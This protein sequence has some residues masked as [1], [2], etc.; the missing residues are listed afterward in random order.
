MLSKVLSPICVKPLFMCSN[1]NEAQYCGTLNGVLVSLLVIC[2]VALFAFKI[3]QSNAYTHKSQ[4]YKSMI[5]A[6]MLIIV[7]FPI[8]FRLTNKNMWTGFDAQRSVL[9]TQGMSDEQIDA[10][11]MAYYNNSSFSSLDSVIN[12]ALPI[13]LLQTQNNRNSSIKNQN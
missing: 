3:W 11:F 6:A 8:V 5:Y 4:I 7:V 13:A 2:F 1:V 9:K 12:K 10:Y